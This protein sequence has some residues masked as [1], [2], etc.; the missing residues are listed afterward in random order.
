MVSGGSGYFKFIPQEEFILVRGS[1]HYI[2]SKGRRPMDVEDN[3]RDLRQMQKE[4][5]CEIYIQ[6]C[7]D[8]GK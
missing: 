1:K 8:F 7:L 3:E 2:S 5:A 4:L 6:R